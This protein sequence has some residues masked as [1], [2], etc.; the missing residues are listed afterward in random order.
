MHFWLNGPLLSTNTKVFL[1]MS[2]VKYESKRAR[3]S[4]KIKQAEKISKQKLILSLMNGA[5]LKWQK[6]Y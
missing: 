6:I 1:S 4:Y 5:K 3:T 2:S